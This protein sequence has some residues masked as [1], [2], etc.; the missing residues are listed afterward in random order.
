MWLSRA[1]GHPSTAPGSGARERGSRSRICGGIPGGAPLARVWI[2]ALRIMAAAARAADAT[3]LFRVARWT[4]VDRG[5]ARWGG[6]GDVNLR[7]YRTVSV[8][9]P[10][11]VTCPS[12]YAPL[13]HLAHQ[14][15][16]DHGGYQHTRIRWM[17]GRM[18]GWKHHRSSARSSS[19]ADTRGKR[20]V[21]PSPTAVESYLMRDDV[22][23]PPR[24]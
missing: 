11:T 22:H 18:E 17:D 21:E 16:E 14:R 1:C 6:W 3:G 9:A 13:T 5:V 19:R 2:S 12:A 8:R 23:K 15:V 10:V 24:G 20:Q 4:T 7:R